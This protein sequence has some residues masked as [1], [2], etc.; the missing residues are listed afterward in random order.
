MKNDLI[1]YPVSYLYNDCNPRALINAFVRVARTPGLPPP[2]V[3]PLQ[4]DDREHARHERPDLDAQTYWPVRGVWVNFASNCSPPIR[5]YV[6]MLRGY[7][8]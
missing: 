6:F 5:R 3:L 4:R 7:S 2:G 8:L 1:L